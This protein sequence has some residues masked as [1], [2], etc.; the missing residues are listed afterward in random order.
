V[1]VRKMS[2]NENVKEEMLKILFIDGLIVATST[3]IGSRRLAPGGRWSRDID[4]PIAFKPHPYCNIEIPYVPATA[5]YGTM[6][7]LL[8]KYYN[9]P[10]NAPREVRAKRIVALIHECENENEKLQCPICKIFSRR[11]PVA[12]F[13]DLEPEG[14]KYNAIP[15]VDRIEYRNE[16]NKPVAVVYVKEENIIPRENIPK[17][18]QEEY[19]DWKMETIPRRVQ[20]VSGNFKLCAKFDM[21]KLCADDLK[22]WFIGLALLEDYYVGRRG[23][24]GYGRINIE[25]EKVRV[26]DSEY[27]V[28]KLDSEKT[29]NVTKI[30]KSPKELLQKWDEFKKE[31][32]KLLGKT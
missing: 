19:K 26:R 14:T 22:P 4:L 20:S 18:I 27:Y 16:S 11:L 24:K 17:N 21:S 9:L 23:S 30:A 10:A 6:R 7:H 8:E 5:F 31:V 28:G 32:E 25:L 15:Q 13:D 29:L 12:L 3:S 1:E 2:F